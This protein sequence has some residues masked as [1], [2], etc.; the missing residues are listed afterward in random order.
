MW[1]FQDTLQKNMKLKQVSDQCF[2][3]LR[4]WNIWKKKKQIL[5]YG[6]NV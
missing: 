5:V 4:D 3:N 6:N 1:N 2:F